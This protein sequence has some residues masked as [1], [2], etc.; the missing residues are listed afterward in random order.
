MPS[1]EPLQTENAVGWMLVTHGPQK[2]AVT[3]QA[4]SLESEVWVLVSPSFTPCDLG[5]VA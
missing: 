3:R 5:Q 2:A 4:R 1:S